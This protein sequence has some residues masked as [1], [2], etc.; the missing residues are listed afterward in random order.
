MS[1]T[2]PCGLALLVFD[3]LICATLHKNINKF[4]EVVRYSVVQGR[5]PLVVLRVDVSTILDQSVDDLLA[6]ALDSDIEQTVAERV[7]AGVE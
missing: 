7:G 2:L 4:G 1:D 6:A 5:V 3:A